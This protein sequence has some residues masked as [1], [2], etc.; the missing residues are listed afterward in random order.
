MDVTKAASDLSWQIWGKCNDGGGTLVEIMFSH[1]CKAN[2]RSKGCDKVSPDT[3]Q[4]ARSV[5]EGCPVIGQCRFWAI[6]TS[7]QFGMAGGL[8][9]TERRAM[10]RK[11]ISAKF[12]IKSYTNGEC[13]AD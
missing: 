4:I 5:C 7:L 1:T 3:V 10:K 11:L 13:D 12:P 2:C 9:V 8:T 6:V